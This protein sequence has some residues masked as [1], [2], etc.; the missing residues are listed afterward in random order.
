MRPVR[1]GAVGRCLWSEQV[2]RPPRPGAA[3]PTPRTWWWW[4]RGYTGL[5]AARTLGRHGASVVVL[6]RERGGLGS[7]RPERRVRSSGLQARSGRADCAEPARAW[8]ARCSVGRWRP[9]ASSSRSSRKSGSPATTCAAVQSP[10]PIGRRTWRS[11]SAS[12]APCCE[13]AGHETLLLDRAE[14][15]PRSDRIDIHGGLLDPAAGSL[16][17]A[18]YCAGLAHA[19]ERAGAQTPGAHGGSRASA[20]WAVGSRSRRRAGRCRLR[21]GRGRDQRVHR[22]AVSSSF[23]GA[24]CPSEVTSWPRRHSSPGSRR[25]LIPGARVLSDTRHLLHYFRLS[26]D[27]RMVFGGRASFTPI[28]HGPLRAPT[29]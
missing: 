2:P 18:K 26:P 23:A 16:H 24:W 11:W 22:S 28:G 17:P 4:A 3:F 10:W 13:V 20:A 21:R 27:R 29:R 19:A 12:G 5:S 7:Q 15:A 14:S 6:E 25:E 9:C 1:S 8:H